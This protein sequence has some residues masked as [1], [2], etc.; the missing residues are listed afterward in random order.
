MQAAMRVAACAHA[1][2]PCHK[3]ACMRVTGACQHDHHSPL[4]ASPSSNNPHHQGIM[5]YLQTHLQPHQLKSATMTGSSAGGLVCVLAACGVFRACIISR[6]P[7]VQ[8]TGMSL[9]TAVQKPPLNNHHHHHH[10]PTEPP[11]RRRPSLR[12]PP[13]SRALRASRRPVAPLGPR[14]CLGGPRAGVAGR[15]AARRR[16]GALQ[17][18]GRRGRG[19]AA[20]VFRD[21]RAGGL[22]G[23]C[24][25]SLLCCRMSLTPLQPSKTNSNPT[26]HPPSPRT[27]HQPTATHRTSRT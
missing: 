17:R 24:A 20:A 21:E 10:P 1:A 7:H 8:L 22:R 25:V 26:S 5:H 13:G 23:G 6:L 4:N 16:G 18:G 12:P 3:P 11:P 15:P 14:L 2:C 27:L 19:D 9:P